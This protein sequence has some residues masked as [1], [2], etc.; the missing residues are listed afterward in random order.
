MGYGF[1]AAIGAKIAMPEKTVIDIAGDA[2][3]QMNIQELST[4]TQYN[5]PVKIINMNNGYLGMVKQWQDMQYE[6]RYSHST[7]E[8]SLPD[9]VKLAEAFGA[10]GIKVSDPALL[11]D[12]IA[13]MIA[14]DGPVVLD[15][16]VEKHENCLPMIPSGNA[17]NEMLLPT[18]EVRAIT[19]AGAN[20]V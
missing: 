4:C 17:H 8:D 12:A 11:D 2:S 1:P 15:C 3:I 16:M 5:V 6:G 7:Y 20:L 18:D 9:F 13:E 14:Y 10:K 19:G